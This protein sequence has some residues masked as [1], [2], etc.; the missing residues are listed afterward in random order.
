MIISLLRVALRPI[1]SVF[2]LCGVGDED[3]PLSEI[4]NRKAPHPKA[5][6]SDVVIPLRSVD[7]SR[8][9]FMACYFYLCIVL[10]E[11]ALD[12]FILDWFIE[13]LLADARRTE[14]PMQKGQYSP[15]LWFW[16]VMF[17]AC[18]TEA[19]KAHST[20]ED[21]HMKTL[22]GEYLDKIQLVS[23]VLRIKTWE[24][25]K[26]ILRLFAWEDDFDGELELKA[27][28]EEAVWTNDVKRQ[29]AQ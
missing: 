28:W 15:S 24:G 22:R 20:S 18:A 3:E 9:G 26:S 29:K 2:T 7:K 12:T 25:A 16:S 6:D 13:Q 17:G 14:V 1:Y 11:N 5:A 10:R 4:L 19:V 8:S 23:Q 27:L 21:S